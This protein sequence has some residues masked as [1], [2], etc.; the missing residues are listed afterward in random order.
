MT[1]LGVFAAIVCTTM[2]YLITVQ[3]TH[4]LPTMAATCVIERPTLTPDRKSGAHWSTAFAGNKNLEALDPTFANQVSAFLEALRVAGARAVVT[5]TR[6]SL[7]QQYV[8]FGAWMIAREGLDPKSVNSAAQV[9]DEWASKTVGIDWLHHNASGEYDVA[10]SVRAAADM[11]AAFH[12]TGRPA[13]PGGAT[14]GGLH[15]RG[16]A[17]DIDIKW[18]G[19]LTLS[20]KKSDGTEESRVIDTQPRTQTNPELAAL[21]RDWFGVLKNR[22]SPNHWSVNGT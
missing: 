6:R 12:I 15:C 1:T 22:R 21:A 19:A 3:R 2:A 11:V 17:V 16:L 13:V 8:M 10:A 7:E 4:A 5:S 9:A 20:H 14:R 18:D